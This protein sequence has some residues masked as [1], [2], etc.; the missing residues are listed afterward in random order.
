MQGLLTLSAGTSV[1][2]E[3]FLSPS[4]NFE[5]LVVFTYDQQACGDFCSVKQWVCPC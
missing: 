4:E 3:E 5:V 2:S 1:P